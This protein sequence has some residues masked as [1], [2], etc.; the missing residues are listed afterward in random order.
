[1]L[2]REDIR[3]A[4]EHGVTQYNM[5]PSAGFDGAPLDGV[6]QSKEALGAR[7]YDYAVAIWMNPWAMRARAVRDR[8]RQA[9]K[10]IFKQ[11]E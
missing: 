11:I 6:R 3:L 10:P 7:P 2:Q 4:C 9:L 8:A 1:L 5:G